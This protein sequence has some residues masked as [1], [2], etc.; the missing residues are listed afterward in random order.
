MA[1]P[2]QPTCTCMLSLHTVPESD[3]YLILSYLILSCLDS[4]FVSRTSVGRQQL[5]RE[6]DGGYVVGANACVGQALLVGPFALL[7]LINRAA[8]S[9]PICRYF[10][11]V[12]EP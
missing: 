11:D 8:F 3:S 10:C 9:Y 5:A 12:A 6:N 1:M 7:A 2:A 4:L